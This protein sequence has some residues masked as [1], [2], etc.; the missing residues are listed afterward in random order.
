MILIDN[1]ILSTFARVDQLELLFRLFPKDSLGVPPA[2]Y[3]ELIEAAE[4]MVIRNKT[5]IF[6]PPPQEKR[7]RRR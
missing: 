4:N 2:V 1:N 7:K 3:D 5:A 6:E